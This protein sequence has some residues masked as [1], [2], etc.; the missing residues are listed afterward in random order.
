MWANGWR[1]STWNELIQPWDIIV[2]GGGITGAGV[3]R[4][5]VAKGTKPFWWMPQIS[6][7]ARPA[8]PPSSFMEGFAT[9]ATNNSMSPVSRCMSANGC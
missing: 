5:A 7:L 1:D 6:H 3:F 9:C 2:I 4:S 8:D